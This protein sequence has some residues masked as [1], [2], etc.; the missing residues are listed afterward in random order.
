M[1]P[2]AITYEVS[3][4]NHFVFVTG[5]GDGKRNGFDILDKWIEETSEEHWKTCTS[6][7]LNP[8]IVDLYRKFGVL[9]VGDTANWSGA[10]WPWWYHSDDETERRWHQKPQVGWDGYFSYVNSVVNDMHRY[11]GDPSLGLADA[12]GRRHSGEPMIP[13]VESIACDIPRLI[14]TNIMNSGPAVPGLPEDFEVEVQTRVSANGIASAGPAHLP[15]PVV[16]HI[17]R[18]RVAPV[19]LELAAYAEGSRELLRE[20]ILTDPWTRSVRQADALIDNI[21]TLPPHEEMRAHYR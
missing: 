5:F 11:A 14:V 2:N 19:E 17:L 13:L 4:V 20:L 1:D 12:L 8:K 15:R 21:L 3:G 9:P 18:E 6:D 16:A 10:S 7:E